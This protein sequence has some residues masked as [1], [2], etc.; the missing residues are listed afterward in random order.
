M[1]SIEQIS[2]FYPPSQQL[3]RRNILREYLQYKILGII[4]RHELSA[5]LSFLG[6][7]ALRLLHGNPRFSEDIDFD[8]VGL[9][10]KEFLTIG[11]EVKKNLEL[12]GYSVELDMVTTKA[13]RCKLR[14]PKLLYDQELSPLES[15]K[16]LIQLDTA[17]H[18]YSYNSES[19]ILAKFDVFS[20]IRT[21]P[22]PILL[23]Q[24]LYAVFNRPRTLGRDFFDITYLLALGVIPDYGYLKLKLGIESELALREHMEKKLGSLD[25]ELLRKDLE[26][27]VFDSHELS[28]VSGFKNYFAQAR[29]S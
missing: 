5:R 26:P 3:M 10:D 19:T 29:L 18:G 9:T 23:S 22:M 16:I 27:F 2:T 7:T 1:I 24:K 4:F 14:F 8:H 15:E 20:V 28:R 21:T 13:L 25:F 12:E 11:K 17:A 6:G